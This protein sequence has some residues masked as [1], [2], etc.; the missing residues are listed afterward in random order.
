MTSQL[1]DKIEIVV[2]DDR[3]P[4]IFELERQ[5]I[6][7]A[8]GGINFSI[9]HIGS[10]A[11]PGLYA[12]PIIDI[13]VSVDVLEDVREY[14]DIMR[15]LEYHNV[16]VDD[17]VER[18]FYVK[19]MPRTHHLHIVPKGTWSHWKHILFRDFLRSHPEERERYGDLKR[20]SARRFP[21][22]RQAYVDSKEEIIEMIL[23]GAVQEKIVLLRVD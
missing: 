10:T 15:G 20:E 3:W 19:G 13:M 2:Y 11:V 14:N 17:D 22:D 12:K 4:G 9:E 23:M 16:P 8:M 5:A 6:S 7:E 21:Y 18:I 1:I